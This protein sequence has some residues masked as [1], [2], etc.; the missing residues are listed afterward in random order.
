MPADHE[1]LRH[2]DRNEFG[3]RA[4]S[5]ALGELA[6]RPAHQAVHGFGAALV[7]LGIA[8]ALGAQMSMGDSWRI[9]VDARERTRL[10]TDGLFGVVRNPIF[11]FMLLSG[12]GLLL[13]LPS[14]FCALAL[15]LTFA[16]IELHVRVVEEPYLSRTH[17]DAYRAYA[18]RVGRFVPGVGRLPR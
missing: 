12:V 15:A 9:G 1:P 18:S 7:S 14:A 4:G 11:S 5:V 2:A 17:G 3:R 10:V 13:L 8:G 6:G 16:G